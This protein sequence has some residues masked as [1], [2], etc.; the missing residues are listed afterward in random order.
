MSEFRKSQAAI[1]RHF[2][3]DWPLVILSI[4]LFTVFAYEFARTIH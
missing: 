4:I 3:I 2:S 1:D